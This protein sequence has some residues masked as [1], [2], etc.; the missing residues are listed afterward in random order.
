MS[1]PQEARVSTAEA[2][3][4]F[5]QQFLAQFG[6]LPSNRKRKA[7][8]PVGGPPKKRRKEQS[9]VPAKEISFKHSAKGTSSSTNGLEDSSENGLHL[10]GWHRDY[11]ESLSLDE[12]SESSEEED[13]VDVSHVPVIVFDSDK[14]QKVTSQSRNGFMAGFVQGIESIQA[15]L[16]NLYNS[17][18]RSPRYVPQNPCPLP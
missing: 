8:E 7:N 18:P 6:P 14:I 4:A 3:E 11:T 5:G 12:S 10:G 2:F 1:S 15:N 9:P 16:I 17:L 13:M